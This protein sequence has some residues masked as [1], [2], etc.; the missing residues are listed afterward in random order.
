MPRI[1]LWTGPDPHPVS[2]PFRWPDTSGA[3]LTNER[4]WCHLYVGR[5]PFDFEAVVDT[6]APCTI[7]PLKMWRRFATH[8]EWLDFASGPSMR[9]GTLAGKEYHFRLGRVAVRLAGRDET[10]ILLPVE[11]VAQFEQFDPSKTDD[12]RLTHTLI[13]TQFGP[14]EGRFLVVSPRRGHSER[15]E[16]WVA[17]ERPVYPL[18]LTS[19][20][21]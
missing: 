10:P 21:L 9:R 8:I 16:A 18:V 6:G 13:G 15:C 5:L 7:F 14:L 19:A 11:V 12:E 2:L 4:L 20:T 3:A 17:D 1:R